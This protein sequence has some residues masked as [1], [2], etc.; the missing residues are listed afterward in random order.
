MTA[1]AAQSHRPPSFMRRQLTLFTVAVGFLTRLPVPS[2]AEYQPVW[3][4]RSAR[5]FPL[6][7]V[8]VGFINAGVWWLCSHWLPKGV[9]V[10]LM[11]AVSLLATGAFHEDGFADVCDGFGGGTTADRTLA[12]MKDSR[13]GAYGAIGIAVLLGL[14]WTALVAVPAIDFPC[15]W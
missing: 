7:G 12:I 11:L 9:S 3:L 4:A 1:A 13:I 14:K 8:L 15:W 2:A 5:Y 10:G 6:V